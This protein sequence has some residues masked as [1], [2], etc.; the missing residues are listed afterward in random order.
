MSKDSL[1]SLFIWYTQKM[2]NTNDPFFDLIQSLEPVAIIFFLFGI[3]AFAIFIAYT[4]R[5]WLVQ[6]A[7]FQMQKDLEDIRNHLLG[8]KDDE[9]VVQ[10]SDVEAYVSKDERKAI[11]AEDLKEL[12]P[13]PIFIALAIGIPVLLIILIFVL[14]IH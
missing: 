9:V 1:V 6:T 8:I 14:N 10:P 3:I 5:L 7:T 13:R 4:I 2:H 12:R 11:L